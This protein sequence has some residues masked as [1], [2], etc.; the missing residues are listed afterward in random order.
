[1]SWPPTLAE[2]K[3]DRNIDPNDTRQDAALAQVLDASVSFVE[4]VR[5]GDYRFDELDPE[6]FDL[7]DPALDKSL[8]LG[9]I[10]YAARLHAR[11]RSD[12]GMVAM[13]ELGSTR[14]S[15]GD[16]D[17]DRLLRIGRHQ[18]YRVG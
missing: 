10:R 3:V 5:A 16:G 1:M 12:D 9:T 8:V 13:G 17:I 6:Q 11:R 7:R 15:T 4:R 18:R 2:L 14:V